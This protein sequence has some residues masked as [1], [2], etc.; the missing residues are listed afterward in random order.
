M[1][2]QSLFVS[3]ILICSWY[4]AVAV[5][6][7]LSLTE[8]RDTALII[9]LIDEAR[10]ILHRSPDSALNILRQALA[11][12]QRINS[13]DGKCLCYAFIGLALNN[14]GKRDE[15]FAYYSKALPYCLK[16]Q[17]K[18]GA[19]PNLYINISSSYFN[20]GDLDSSIVYN[21]KALSYLQ[22]HQPESNNI[23]IVYS[24]LSAVYSSQ[25]NYEK[26]LRFAG[27]ADKIATERNVPLAQVPALINMGNMYAVLDEPDSALYCFEKGLEV[28]RLNGYIDR[29]QTLLCSIGDMILEAG[30]PHKAIHYYKQALSLDNESNI[31][32][33]SI[34]PGYH[35]GIAYFRTKRY[36]AAEQVLLK[37]IQIAESTGLNMNKY[38][39][40]YT[41][42]EIYETTGRYKASLGQRKT[43][44]LLRDSLY[45]VE[46]TKAIN[47]IEHKYNIAQKDKTI[48]QHKLKMAQQQRHIEKITLLTAGGIV[49]VI[50][51]SSIIFIVYR[52]RR[53]SERKEEE[54]EK[55]K[56]QMTGEESERKRI[57]REL[58][59]G[60]GGLLTSARLN[61]QNMKDKYTDSQQSDLRNLS[62]LL[63]QVSTEVQ[64]TAHNLMPD[65]LEERNLWFALSA[66]CDQVERSWKIPIELHT[67][68]DAGLL[69]SSISLPL[70]RI[71]QELV[72]N[73]VKHSG[74]SEIFVQARIDIETQRVL[75]SV[76]D[77][78]K[79][80]D[81]A[82][83]YNGLGLKSIKERVK[84]LN[85]FISI[86]SGKDIGTTI[87]IDIDLRNLN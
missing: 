18:I 83:N 76:E 16:P 23:A 78:G 56:A 81:T 32:Y 68:G 12:S 44:E 15:G 25:G 64:H 38:I 80:F 2:K 48:A 49:V 36:A 60:I 51:V 72:Q 4:E 70:Y 85:G 6:R 35:L 50:L 11:I 86:A 14:E 24:N 31:Y 26:A 79:G 54:L 59:D 39:A 21:Y 62:E 57:S 87:F 34:V 47:E 43:G 9:Q 1:G 27:M 74:G 5:P 66:Y 10:P 75:L 45:N 77:N 71:A 22:E 19:L 73:A 42:S 33:G 41:L 17:Y 28:A 82:A 55:L 67:M 30:D 29:E 20:S 61:I 37:A 46:K 3:L 52:N 65:V 58:H 7:Q 13:N 53:R 84:V 40:H 8:Q 69:N 63:T